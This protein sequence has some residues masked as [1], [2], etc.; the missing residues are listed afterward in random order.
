MHET[1]F[2][3]EFY[4]KALQYIIGAGKSEQVSFAFGF[5]QIDK[6][7]VAKVMGE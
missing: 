2:K 6:H 5:D 1:A 3:F 7:S 4:V